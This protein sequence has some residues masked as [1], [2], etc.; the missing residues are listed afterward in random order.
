MNRKDDESGGNFKAQ[1][2]KSRDLEV[3]VSGFCR[4]CFDISLFLYFYRLFGHARYESWAI[5][6]LTI[7]AVL[8]DRLYYRMVA[9]VY[10]WIFSRLWNILFKV[11]NRI[12]MV[13]VSSVVGNVFKTSFLW[14]I[15]LIQRR[16]LW[17][18]VGKRSRFL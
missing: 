5:A 15:K 10:G 3:F 8:P 18:Y 2:G 16:V 12:S 7:W 17:S 4:I 6:D 13:H 9:T 11:V 14:V 1:M